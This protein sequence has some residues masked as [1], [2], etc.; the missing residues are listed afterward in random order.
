[1]EDKNVLEIEKVENEIKET[2]SEL[3]GE[4]IGAGFLSLMFVCI[5]QALKEGRLAVYGI[6]LAYLIYAYQTEIVPLKE[7]L[8]EK[9]NKLTELRK[10]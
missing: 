4:A 8:K 7:T 6:A 2:K 10:G 1:M 3:A 5:A 9:K